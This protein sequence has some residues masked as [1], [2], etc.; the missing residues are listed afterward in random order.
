MKATKTQRADGITI[1]GEWTIA[2]GHI[3]TYTQQSFNGYFARHSSTETIYQCSCGKSGKRIA[4][5]L[6]SELGNHE[7]WKTDAERKVFIADL[8]SLMAS[9]R[10]DA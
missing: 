1:V 4:R 8:A 6:K 2:D 5:A 3:V 9:S 7:S 10:V